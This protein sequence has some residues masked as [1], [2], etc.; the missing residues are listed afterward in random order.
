MHAAKQRRLR[1]VHRFVAE[2]A[3]RQDSQRIGFPGHCFSPGD[4][5]ARIVWSFENT[6]SRRK[7][8]V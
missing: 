6:V 2:D 5:P 1:R 3:E 4:E 8:I 7:R